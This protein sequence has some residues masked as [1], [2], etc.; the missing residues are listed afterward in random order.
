MSVP[1]TQEEKQSE[2]RCCFGKCDEEAVVCEV[3]SGSRV[4]KE[5]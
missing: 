3:N 1:E 5:A 4:G 2:N